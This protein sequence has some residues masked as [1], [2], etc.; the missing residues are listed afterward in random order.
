MASKDRRIRRIAA[1]AGSVAVLAL[2]AGCAL[3][4][5]SAAPPSVVVG[6]DLNLTGRGDTLGTAFHNGLQ[7][8]LE[9]VREQGLA[10]AASIELRVL[11][12]RGD[13]ATAAANLAELS[14]DR[15][16]AAIITAGCPQ[17]LLDIADGLSVPVISLDGVEAVA[18]PAAERRWVFRIGPSAADNADVLSLAMAQ[19]GV[20]TVA[21]VARVPSG[22]RMPQ[23]GTVSGSR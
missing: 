12:N 23:R 16:V 17:C 21:V 7:L 10:G 15:S 20:E 1:I 4:P 9:R 19:A 8:Q 11:D 18:A 22:P 5:S 14:A 3:A 6:V 2:T 13:P